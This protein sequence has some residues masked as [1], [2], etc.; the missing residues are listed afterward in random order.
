MIRVRRVGFKPAL[1][2]D[3][4]CRR[5]MRYSMKQKRISPFKTGF[6]KGFT[7]LELLVVIAIIAMLLAVVMPSL[8]RA[9]QQAQALVCQSN[10]KQW[11]VLYTMY[12]QDYKSSLPVGWNG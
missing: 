8:K 12:A 6:G 10:L 2:R 11:G 7:L 4:R 3:V 1:L 5:K 9:K